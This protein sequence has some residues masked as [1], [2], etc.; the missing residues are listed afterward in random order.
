MVELRGHSFHVYP[1]IDATQKNLDDSLAI[2]IKRA[3]RVLRGVD[4]VS[5]DFLVL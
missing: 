4:D 2:S 5:E 3:H 1:A